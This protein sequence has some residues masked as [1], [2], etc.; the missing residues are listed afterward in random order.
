VEP[1]GHNLQVAAA[2]FEA[3]RTPA[4]LVSG[5]VGPADGK[6]FFSPARDSN[7]GRVGGSGEAV[8]IVSMET[9]L[10]KLPQGATVDLLKLD[11]E[12]GEQSL[13]DGDRSW[14]RRVR[15]LMVEFHPELVDVKR[16]TG[17]IRDEG[18]RFIP[19]GSTNAHSADTFIRLGEPE[20]GENRA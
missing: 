11:I 1:D 13:L 7:L 5:A 12:G 16:L 3:N 2:N 14:L 9:L 10:A 18:F 20:T 8:E 4:Q 19:A 15:A 6:G 17:V